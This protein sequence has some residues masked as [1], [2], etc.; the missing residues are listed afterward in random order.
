MATE[1]PKKEAVIVG[2][3]WTGSIIA[4]EL[5]KE[6]VEVLGLERGK[7][8]DLK[9]YFVVHDELRYAMRYEALILLAV[10]SL[11]PFYMMIINA[12]RSNGEI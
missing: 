9:D 5:A 8:R 11:I 10:I 6:G 3:G 4:A 12:T 1:L 7:A 2:M